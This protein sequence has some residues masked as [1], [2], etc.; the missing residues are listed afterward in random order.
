[1]RICRARYS[2]VSRPATGLLQPRLRAFLPAGL[3]SSSCPLYALQRPFAWQQPGRGC[4]RECIV[5]L[6]PQLVDSHGTSVVS[7]CIKAKKEG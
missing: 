3:T 2:L 5:L 1:M 6:N 4:P 7:F